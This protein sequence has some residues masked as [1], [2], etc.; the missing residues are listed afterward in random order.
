MSETLSQVRV[1]C[2]LEAEFE[3]FMSTQQC[4]DCLM[5]GQDADHCI[6]CMINARAIW[7]AGNTNAVCKIFEIIG[8]WYIPNDALIGYRKKLAARF[9]L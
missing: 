6:N 7:D 4:S 2:A 9:G 5:K 3:H 1:D 8:E